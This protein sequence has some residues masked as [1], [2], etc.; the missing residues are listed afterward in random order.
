MGICFVDND[1]ILKLAACNLFEEAL[2]SFNL[3]K[4]DVRVLPSASFKFR[5]DNRLAKIYTM[6]GVER[7]IEIVKSCVSI[8]QSPNAAEIEALTAI[9][10]IDAGEAVLFAT[11]DTA[12]KFYILTGDKRCLKALASSSL[13][14]I[15]YRISGRVLCFEQIILRLI[16]TCGFA[17][18]KAKVVPVRECDTAL[19]V[20]FGSGEQSTVENTIFTLQKY[21]EELRDMTQELLMQDLCND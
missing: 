9:E 1:I 20:A 7:A 6:V 16:E 15:K 8:E 14:D 10:G 21:I 19:K 13:K 17:E 2:T 12:N 4:A 5:K 18:V 11:T 3:T